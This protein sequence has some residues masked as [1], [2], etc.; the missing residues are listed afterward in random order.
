M[1]AAS[2]M[3]KRRP[4][5]ATNHHMANYDHTGNLKGLHGGDYQK[6]LIKVIIVELFYM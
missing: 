3:P 6:E 1:K 2:E 5:M 4:I